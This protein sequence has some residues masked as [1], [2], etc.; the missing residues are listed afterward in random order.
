MFAAALTV[1]LLVTPHLYTYDLTL[2]LLVMLL[3][4]NSSR[5]TTDAS[6]RRSLTVA[7]V[8]LYLPLYPL[9]FAHGASFL[10]VPV[11]LVFALNGGGTAVTKPA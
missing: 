7:A 5:W 3:M 1:S 2:M 9:L 11:L 4:F 8:L 10:L 6:C